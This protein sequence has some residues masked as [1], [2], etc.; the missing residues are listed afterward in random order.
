M[1][2]LFFRQPRLLT[3]TIALIVVAGLSSFAVLPRAEDPE[4]IGRNA[5]VFTLFPGA[6]AERVE[7]LVS[8]PLEDALRE[9]EEVHLLTSSSR[10]GISTIAVELDESIDDVD[11]VWSRIRDEISDV[12]PTLP[13]GAGAPDLEEFTITA[14]TRIVGLVWEDGAPNRAILR[15]LGADLA[16]LLRDVP[17]TESTELFGEAEEEI[18]LEVDP[19]LL[20][21]QGLTVA[22]VAAATAAADAKLPAGSL[23][24]P[25][26]EVRLEVEGELD[27][28]AR[29]AE[30][31]IESGASGR[32]V[33]LSDLG[34]LTKSFRD[35]AS[36]LALIAGRPGVVVAA[37]MLPGQR[38]DRWSS[39]ASA[40]LAA[41]RTQLPRGVRLETL[42]E[43][44]RYTTERL[45]GLFGN[46][47]LGAGAVVLV[48]LLMM[49]WRSALLVG[50]ALPLTSLMV[51]TGM[52]FL[53]I[54]INQM[55]V[56]G[57][58]IALGLLI[59]N[60]I[61]VVDEMRHR[62]DAG[63]GARAAVGQTVRLLAAPLVGS[64]LTTVLAFMPIVLMPGSAGEFVGPMAMSVVLAVASSL[65]LALTV[66][67]ALAGR[68]AP[69]EPGAGLLARGF[70]SE[71]LT[72]ATRSFLRR[73]VARPVLAFAIAFTLPIAG[74]VG[75]AQLEE[76]FFPPAD[77]DQ[78]VLD[79]TLERHASLDATRA[80]A[81][82][83]REQMLA[84]PEVEEV[85]WFVGRSAPKFYYNLVESQR[86]APF[87]AQAIVQLRSSERPRETIS[88]LQRELDQS[89]PGAQTLA[90]QIEQ[91]PPFEAPVELHVTG[92]NLARLSAIGDE[93][94]A[95]L[96]GLPDVRHT[97]AKLERGEP[98]LTLVLDEERA[99]L[100]GLD[101]AAVAGFLEAGLE[102]VVGGS[103]LEA[104]EELPVRVR[105]R[106]LERRDLEE[107]AALALPVGGG[108]E[109]TTLSALGHFE[110][111]PQ[112]A[113]IAHRGGARSNTVQAYLEAGALPA[114]TLGKLQ[115]Q[116]VASSFALPEGYA[117]E[118]G[119]E[120]SERDD[121]V[122]A[123]AATAGILAVLMAAA[124]VLSL[125]SFALALLIAAV[126]LLSVGL[127][128]GNVWLF[129]HPFGFMAIVGTM[130][131]VGVAINDSI[132][133][134]AALRNDERA[135]AGDREAIADVTLRS[136]R[137]VASTTLTTAAGFAPLVL[138]GGV[139]WPP[140]A[141]A[142]GGGVLGAT[143][144]ALTFV[145]AGFALLTA[146]K[147]GGAT[148]PSATAE[149][150][151]AG[152]LLFT[153]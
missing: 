136:V 9:V 99:R 128:L 1:Q 79:L 42:F 142:I 96:A 86:N 101:N 111:A 145:P 31:P 17:G 49:G 57:L 72:R 62:L 24:S 85:H 5:T 92:P 114:K 20:S 97:R 30:L 68:L 44:S 28:L 130:G 65:F 146:R 27:S 76:Q 7:A 118:I 14:Y 38:V 82:A 66:I 98:Q 3:L 2:D 93:L 138:A 47:A 51:L 108:E 61:V 39:R 143:L 16:D 29:V 48:V 6:S 110:L 113:D 151:P 13:A 26:S 35:P 46:F 127:A 56:T 58:I 80:V 73:I 137:H 144:L 125:D 40:D 54:P 112:L 63:V 107:I 120:A 88:A 153:T 104:T 22:D 18:L 50:T 59:D 83:M 77:R 43:Q 89:F 8:Q 71:R 102:G 45:S 23:R 37:R 134:L 100:L 123:L 152:Q 103:V 140:V 81:L 122:T 117:L 11:V 25:G 74:F 4:L 60:A 129:G 119:G 87:Y 64:T 52:R 150:A 69:A 148:A 135:R 94:R 124:L 91:G 115:E 141:V 67:P 90:R 139:F 95:T 53:G 147:V 84:Q 121:A 131:L 55:S 41:F 116:L 10:A 34:T 21:A 15:R 36:D 109:W 75:G 149:P 78:F 105:L 19:A 133:V 12:E 132:V 70:A 106:G 33:P 32:F 126:G